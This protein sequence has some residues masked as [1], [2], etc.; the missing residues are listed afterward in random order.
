MITFS[1]QYL[2]NVKG[3]I[4][5]QQKQAGV[6]ND[7]V[8]KLIARELSEKMG[9]SEISSIDEAHAHIMAYL[10]GAVNKAVNYNGDVLMLI[11][12]EQSLSNLESGELVTV[13]ESEASE[14]STKHY[15]RILLDGQE[16]D[17]D[18]TGSLGSVPSMDFKS[19]EMPSNH[20]PERE[21]GEG[22]KRL[23]PNASFATQAAQLLDAIRPLV[24]DAVKSEI[25]N[26]EYAQA[27]V[28]AEQYFKYRS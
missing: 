9:V 7:A 3:V 15:Y 11:A 1:E 28:C 17:I 2:E 8:V 20:I 23:D 4:F 5:G 22:F 24:P 18:N 26:N 10:N 25:P 19:E 12:G 27:L 6:Q 14:S 13:T 16:P 21:R